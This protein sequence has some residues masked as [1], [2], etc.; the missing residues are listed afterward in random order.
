[1]SFFFFQAEDGI[2]DY[3]VTGVQTCALPISLAERNLGAEGSPLL[4]LHRLALHENPASRFDTACDRERG[5]VGLHLVR[6]LH[7]EQ[8]PAEGGD[9]HA[10]LRLTLADARDLA[11]AQVDRPAASG[12]VYRAGDGS[13]GD[14]ASA[15][16]GDEEVAAL[17]VRQGVAVLDLHIEIALLPH[18]GFDGAAHARAQVL[19]A[20]LLQLEPA[21]LVKADP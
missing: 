13:D 7:V 6:P 21:S 9:R 15:V 4:D 2:R 3:K 1:M 12:D 19:L 14:H 16:G 8:H 17:A 5:L 20:D 18:L 10:R 11:L